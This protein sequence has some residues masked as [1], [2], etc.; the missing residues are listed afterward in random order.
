MNVAD[1]IAALTTETQRH[2]TE[3]TRIL[4]EF[5]G[6]AD[7]ISWLNQAATPGCTPASAGLDADR[8]AR[9]TGD[10]VRAVSKS[11]GVIRS[12]TPGNENTT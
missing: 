8:E 3:I 12:I 9:E 2:H 7:A 11:L 4:T 10:R 1:F 5:T 6:T